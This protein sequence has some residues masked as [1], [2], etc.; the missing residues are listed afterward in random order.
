MKIG[1]WVIFLV[2]VS[3]SFT[4]CKDFWADDDD[5]QI[6]VGLAIKDETVFSK[7]ELFLKR[8]LP[9][10]GNMATIHRLLVQVRITFFCY[11]V[12]SC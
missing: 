7:L 2:V 5:K 3:F 8:I 1:K 10:H 11:P 6:V 4:S 12:K 9:E